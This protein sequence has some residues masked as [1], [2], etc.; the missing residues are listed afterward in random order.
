MTK[1]LLVFISVAI[2]MLSLGAVLF[3]KLNPEWHGI[4]EN[5]EDM[6]AWLLSF[7]A[8]AVL[9]SIMVMI[10]QTI[11][12]VLLFYQGLPC[13]YARRSVLYRT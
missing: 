2:V 9:V 8:W 3:D 5:S 1:K 10:I 13:N 11:P 4:F 7:G 12:G 6:A